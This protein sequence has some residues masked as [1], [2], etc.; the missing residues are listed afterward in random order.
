MDEPVKLFEFIKSHKFKEFK[1]ILDE[2]SNNFI[3]VN[4]RDDQN[5]YLLS[6]AI[7]FNKIDL[8]ELL[9]KKGAKIDITDTDDRSILYIPIKYNYIEIIK[10][11][12]QANI[13]QIGISIH[14]IKDRNYNI[15][16]HYTIIYKNIEALKIMLE[17]GSNP[18][19]TDKF[20]N[21]SLH[22]SVYSRNYDICRYILNYD[23]D[24][25]SKT[26]IG[27]SA[28]HIAANL[29]VS[30]IFNLLVKLPNINVNTQDYDHEFTPLH[31]S[32]NLNNIDQVNILLQKNANPN[33]QDIYGNTITH[34]TV[35]EE[36][37]QM[38]NIITKFKYTEYPLNYNLWNIDGKLALHIIFNIYP[39]NLNQYI[40]LLLKETNINIPDNNGDTCLLYICKYNIWKIYKTILVNKKLDISIANRYQER[41]ID[42]IE[43]KDINEFIDIVTQS[44]LNRLRNMKTSWLQEWENICNKELLVEHLS[45]Y[46]KK[47]IKEMNIELN[48]N[49]NKKIDVCSLIVERRVRDIISKKYI[50]NKCF[51]KSYPLKQG[52]ICINL[53]NNTGLNFCTFTGSTLDILIGIIYLLKKHPDA[54]STLNTDFAE[55]IKLC[56]FYKNM[57]I[58]VSSRC[59][60]MNFEIVWVY[61]KLYLTDNFFDNFKKCISDKNK[62][63]IIIPLGIEMKEG[64]HANYLIYDKNLQEIERFEPHGSSAPIGFNYNPKLLDQILQNRIRDINPN[65]IYISP[66]NYL[67]KIGFQILDIIERDN[68][69]IGDPGGFCALWVIWYTDMRITNQNIPRKTLVKKMLS[70]MKSSG[71]SFKNLIRNYSKNIID[72]RDKYFRELNID[73]NDWINDKVSDEKIKKLIKLIGSDVNKLI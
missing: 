52:N 10:I 36:N 29:Q 70:Q 67:P 44:Y 51:Y 59:E 49:I 46:E 66:E 28:L 32:V 11:L 48:K 15:P 7:L 9:I 45:D 5:N 63:F 19:I 14:D 27:E 68:K 25:N 35:M 73:I 42:F 56:N 41:P 64:S 38:L 55:N 69:K 1:N 3:D 30:K 40:D 47:V 6:Y 23:I 20:G 54:C 26:N 17:Y 71:I 62:R 58:S 50:D 8:V 60:F 34:Y 12:L 61:N 43:D 16:I 37:I 22:L 72:I 65:I 18:N 13:D 2:D 31:Y 4:I 57:G 39:Q 21:N 33:I 53:Q 24:I